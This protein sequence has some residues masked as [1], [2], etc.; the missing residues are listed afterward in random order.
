MNNNY[1]LNSLELFKER[2]KI[3]FNKNNTYTVSENKNNNEVDRYILSKKVGK[4]VVH[5][6][7]IYLNKVNKEILLIY[8]IIGKGKFEVKKEISD[9]VFY[10]IK[11]YLDDKLPKK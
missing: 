2:V 5:S 8:Y 4:K 10:N 6:I 11:K 3:I 1:S 7:I 9:E